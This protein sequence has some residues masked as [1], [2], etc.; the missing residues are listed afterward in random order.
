MPPFRAG[1]LTAR[2]EVL[3]PRSR[4]LSPRTNILTRHHR[5]AAAAGPGWE[6][7]RY[8][9]GGAVPEGGSGDAIEG[10]AGG[11]SDG[12]ADP[13]YGEVDDGGCAGCT[14]RVSDALGRSHGDDE[15]QNRGG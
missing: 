7:F 6:P 2:A 1:G 9:A 11:D 13:A 5:G 15:G 10:A 12:C 3:Q 4:S 14:D 8:C